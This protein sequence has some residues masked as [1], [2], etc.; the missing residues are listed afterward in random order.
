MMIWLFRLQKIGLILKFFYNLDFSALLTDQ[1]TFTW[2]ERSVS[3]I[4]DEHTKS[5]NGLAFTC[6]LAALLTENPEHFRKLRDRTVYN[7]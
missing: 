1:F 3:K 7:K 6:Q 5:I 4:F 2:I